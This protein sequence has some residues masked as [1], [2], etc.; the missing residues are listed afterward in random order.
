MHDAPSGGICS[1]MSKALILLRI[2]VFFFFFLCHGIV[3]LE[4]IVEGDAICLEDALSCLHGF[5][6]LN[7][8]HQRDNLGEKFRVLISLL[9]STDTPCFPFPNSN[10][11]SEPTKG[12]RWTLLILKLQEG[13]LLLLQ[14]V[15][16]TQEHWLI[17]H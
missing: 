11:F 7:M 6:F 12:Q 8:G 17:P 15:Q 4:Q 13:S 1:L 3:P 5:L 16:N 14:V 2:L 10:C 9:L